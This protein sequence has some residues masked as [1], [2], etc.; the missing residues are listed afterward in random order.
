M[1]T[2]LALLAGIGLL[3]VA[4]PLHAHHS[5]A[6]EFDAAKPFT[7]SGTVTKVVWANPHAW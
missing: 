1:R 3:V 6:A 2:D 7:L 5:F 4:Q